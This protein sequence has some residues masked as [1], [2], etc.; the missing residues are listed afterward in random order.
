MYVLDGEAMEGSNDGSD[1]K[2]NPELIATL[3]HH[4]H[5]IYF[6][7]VTMRANQMNTQIISKGTKQKHS[8]NDNFSEQYP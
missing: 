3:K 2:Q 8:S 6:N 5:K 7:F 1:A 4:Y